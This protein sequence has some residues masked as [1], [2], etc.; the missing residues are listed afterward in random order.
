[1]PTKSTQLAEIERSINEEFRDRIKKAI[2]KTGADF[3]KLVGSFLNVL[4]S[5]PELQKCTKNSLLMALFD[6]GQTGLYPGIGNRCHIIKYGDQAQFQ[7]GYKGVKELA[8]RHPQVVL[9]RP[10]E[11]VYEHDQFKPT[12]GLRPDLEHVPSETPGGITGAYCVAEMKDAENV[13][14]YM[15]RD[16]L[17]ARMKRSPAVQKGRSSPWTT[18]FEAMCKKTAVIELC[19]RLPSQTELDTA[20]EITRAIDSGETRVNP[21]MDNIAG[22]DAEPAKTT[23]ATI[24]KQG[25]ENSPK[26]LDPPHKKAPATQQ[27]APEAPQEAAEE[28][29]K[30]IVS[31]ETY[32]SIHGL[33][34]GLTDIQKKF[35]RS[36]YGLNLITEVKGWSAEN[37]ETFLLDLRDQEAAIPA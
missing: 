15:R 10:P 14:I 3:D 7:L 11:V 9:I 28:T 6:C 8:E 30:G 12:L 20:I 18:D 32:K 24:T 2:A 29:S 33:W 25:L 22:Q 4:A 17:D 21:L 16:Q 1:M 34:L 5:K 19:N 36:N 13:F 37:A 23:L 35:F 26:K 27:A 31:G